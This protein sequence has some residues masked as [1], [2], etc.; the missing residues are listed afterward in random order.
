MKTD[1]AG[2]SM[3]IPPVSEPYNATIGAFVEMLGNFNSKEPSVP[4]KIAEIV[5][6]VS[7]ME[8]PPLRLLVGSDA[9]D[10]GRK[11]GESLQESDNKFQ[12]LI[13]S[14]T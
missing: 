3:N 10:I 7:E 2:S 9:I 4:S 11:A 12:E 6:K 8:K 14:S 5:L 1:W 13:L